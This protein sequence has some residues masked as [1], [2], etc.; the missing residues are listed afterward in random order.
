[1]HLFDLISALIS[2]LAKALPALVVISQAIY[3][4]YKKNPF[5]GF[6]R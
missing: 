1:M 4:H 5:F 6:S 2:D 3:Y